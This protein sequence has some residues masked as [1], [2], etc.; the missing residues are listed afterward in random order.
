VQY[1]TRIPGN[2]CLYI[3]K[4]LLSVKNVNYGCKMPSIMPATFVWSLRA[5]SSHGGKKPIVELKKY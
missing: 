4:T 3:L 1:G 2:F 5:F